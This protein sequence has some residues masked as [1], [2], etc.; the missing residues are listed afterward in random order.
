LAHAVQTVRGTIDNDFTIAGTAVLLAPHD[1]VCIAPRVAEVTIDIVIDDAGGI[2]LEEDREAGVAGPRCVDPS[3]Y[4]P[5]PLV[6]R[7]AE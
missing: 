7:P 1:C 6:L 4:C 2:R 5:A 3:S